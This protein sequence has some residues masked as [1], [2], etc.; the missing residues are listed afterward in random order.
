MLQAQ[1]V[2]LLSQRLKT[3]SCSSGA[4]QRH[5][6]RRPSA[7]A[8][9][10]TTPARHTRAPSCS[11][12][13][14]LCRL[15][16]LGGLLRLDLGDTRSHLI[17][18]E[19]SQR[20]AARHDGHLDVLAP[21]LHYLQQGLDRELDGVGDA[22][23]ILLLEELANVLRLLSGRRCLPRRVCAGRISLVELRLAGRIKATDQERDTERPN[24][25]PLRVPLLDSCHIPR[26]VLDRRRVLKCEAVA[27]AL[28]TCA[29][30]EHSRV[31]CEP[32]E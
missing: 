29:V 2:A 17:L 12:R 25:W 8:T 21:G 15:F 27:L 10:R 30:N 23:I 13:A 31:G 1:V 11:C 19:Q 14:W 18:G 5:Q 20:L 28:H 32:R 24:T 9:A 6:A 22:L 3:R 26:N 7:A 16:F 4:P